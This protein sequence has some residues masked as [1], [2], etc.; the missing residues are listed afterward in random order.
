M[1]RKGEKGKEGNKFPYLDK[2]LDEGRGGGGQEEGF[3]FPSSL[4]NTIPPQLER[5]RGK[6]E[7]LLPLP[8]LSPPFPPLLLPFLYLL[9]CYPNKA[10]FTKTLQQ[11]PTQGNEF[12]ADNLFTFAAAFY[13]AFIRVLNVMFF[14]LNCQQWRRQG[15]GSQDEI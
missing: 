8:F 9:S 4:L 12:S 1:G 7:L 14:E 6:W 15:G 2:W 5:F 11:L 3:I 13:K 10:S